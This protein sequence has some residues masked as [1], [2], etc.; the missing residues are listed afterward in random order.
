MMP[1]PSP[2]SPDDRTA[3]CCGC[4]ATLPIALYR[5][6][7][8][9][10]TDTATFRL[11]RCGQCGLV[12][13]E[14]VLSEAQ[15]GAYYPADYYGG[16]SHKFTALVEGFTRLDN[17]RRARRLLALIC[18]A[19]PKT[20]EP[21]RILDVGC[22]RA[23][24]LAALA[25]LGCEC[26]GVERQEFPAHA[27]YPGIRFHREGL[28]NLPATAADVDA[29][30]FWHTLEHMSDPAAALR[31][32]AQRLR[33]GGIVALAVPHFSSWQARLFKSAW[34]HLD[35]PRHTHHFDRAVLE[36]LLIQQGLRPLQISTWAFD[37][38]VFGFVQSLLN[39]LAG[40]G[41]ANELY[42]LLKDSRGRKGQLLGWLAAAGV[43]APLALLEY[44]L[45]GLLGRGATL[46]VYARK[47][48]A[49][50]SE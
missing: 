9:D 29:A 27:A 17:R 1:L 23:H 46:I 43:I 12:R 2:V 26:H 31:L 4:G 24:L 47:A 36:R 34:F 48:S 50:I 38:N 19:G 33:P 45:S 40:P 20:P 28:E 22:G 10:A 37:Q 6:P 42:S 21:A 3:P 18:A 41:R 25:H 30:V 11:V 35:L 15:L 39:V 7:A 32:V 13:T 44:L 14:P 16:G 5:A 8:F 49:S